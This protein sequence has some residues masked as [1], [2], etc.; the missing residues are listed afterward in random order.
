MA[1]PHTGKRVLLVEDDFLLREMLTM[2][3]AGE[4]YMVAT[5][6]DGEDALR[7]LRTYERPD[8]ILLDLMMPHMD[9]WRFRQEQQRDPNLAPIPVVVFSAAGDVERKSS[10]LAARSYLQKPVESRTLLD[11]VHTC[12]A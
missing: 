11:T 3:L 2:L 8:L 1:A 7:R 12:C 5:A 4:G 10:A 9:G 6:A